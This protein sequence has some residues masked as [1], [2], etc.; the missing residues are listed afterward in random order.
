MK[1]LKSLR[2][3]AFASP[4][5]ASRAVGEYFHA[6]EDVFSNSKASGVNSVVI[7]G[8]FDYYGQFEIVYPN[9]LPTVLGT[10]G[11]VG[12][13]N[14][15]GH[16]GL[17][18]EVDWTW[19]DWEKASVMTTAVYIEMQKLAISMGITGVAA[20]PSPDAIALDAVSPGGTLNKF[21]RME[22]ELSAVYWGGIYP[23]DTVTSS[24]YQDKVRI[25]F[26]G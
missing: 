12:R 1:R 25:L 17:G 26:P 3:A 22:P 4:T 15:L 13:H 16:A 9:H 11:N 24:G 20:S 18:H 8:D 2:S 21:L 7:N 19:M 5:P 14:I 23:V 6:L 10:S